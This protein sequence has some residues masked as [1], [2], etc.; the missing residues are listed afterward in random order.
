[1]AMEFRRSWNF[2]V[3]R[4]LSTADLAKISDPTSDLRRA[5]DEIFDGLGGGGGTGDGTVVSVNGVEPDVDGML[6]LAYTDLSLGTASLADVED[7]PLSDDA[8]AA[9]ATKADLVGGV[10]PSAQ[11]PSVNLVDVFTVASQAAMLALS[12]GPGDMAVRTDTNTVYVLAE[13]P[14]ATLANWKGP[15]TL[16]GVTTVAGK[17]GPAV[18]LVKG[19]VGLGNVDNTTDV[20][21]PVST[22][23]S[24]A[25]AAAVL[26][27]TN[28]RATDTARRKR[29]TS[30]WT[31]SAWPDP[32]TVPAGWGVD[33]FSDDPA[34]DAPPLVR[35][36]D[37]FY[38]LVD[39]A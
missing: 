10:V 13:A 31:G 14:A 35:G 5:L 19:D 32:G 3:S 15:L 24:T 12:A 39:P 25:I 37:V 22:A 7:L 33:W 4:L 34:C 16:G 1:M 23:T 2:D 18:S 11:L 21:K 28:A 9:L 36:I 20:N 30:V 17:A 8:I 38:W 27:E 29:L 6:V 26:V